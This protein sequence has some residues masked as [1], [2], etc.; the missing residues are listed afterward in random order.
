M[1]ISSTTCFTGFDVLPPKFESPPY[2]PHDRCCASLRRRGGE[3]RRATALR[4]R[5][6]HRLALHKRDSLSIRRSRGDCRRKGHGLTIGAS[7][8]AHLVEN[9]DCDQTHGPQYLLP[10]MFESASQYENT[11]RHELSASIFP[12]D[13]KTGRCH[14]YRKSVKAAMQIPE[15]AKKRRRTKPCP[16]GHLVP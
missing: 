5:S 3:H 2:T 15:P 9:A 7:S 10:R 6:K 11:Y 12:S 8:H 1:A 4:S 14:S 13:S 16:S